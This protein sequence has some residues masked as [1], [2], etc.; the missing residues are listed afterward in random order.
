MLGGESGAA[1]YP[2]LTGT[3]PGLADVQQVLLSSEPIASA[4]STSPKRSGSA[5][6]RRCGWSTASCSV[7]T[8]PRALPGLRY[9][10]ELAAT[11]G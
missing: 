1:R 6:T 11:I 4:R 8:G 7:G 9:L 5:R 2:A 10:R 3:E